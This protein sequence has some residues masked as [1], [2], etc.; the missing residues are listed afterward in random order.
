[1]IDSAEAATIK[2]FLKDFADQLR[3]EGVLLSDVVRDRV[4]GNIDRL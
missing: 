3:T 2:R 1:M 4:K